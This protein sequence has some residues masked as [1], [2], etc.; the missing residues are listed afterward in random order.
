MSIGHSL[1]CLLEGLKE[2]PAP[3]IISR[4]RGYCFLGTKGTTETWKGIILELIKLLTPDTAATLL[5]PAIDLLIQMF[6]QKFFAVLPIPKNLITQ[7]CELVYFVKFR[8]KAI[9]ALNLFV[10][11]QNVQLVAN[12]FQLNQ[13]EAKGNHEKTFYFSNNFLFFKKKLFS[14]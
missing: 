9:Q 6:D 7:L 11:T 12:Y 5:N 1:F 8:D 3:K 13:N 14:L 10:N 2:N 4:I